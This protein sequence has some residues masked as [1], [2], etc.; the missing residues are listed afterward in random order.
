MHLKQSLFATASAVLLIATNAQAQEA[1][2]ERES[3]IDRVLGTVTVT[4]T[5]K[6]DVEN[7]Q[8]VPVAVTA[9]NSDTLDALNVTT[10][11]SLS[12]SSPNVSLDDVG[13]SRGTANFAIRGLGVNSSIPS[14]DPAV[15]VFIDGVY[16]GVN[17]GVVIDLFDVDS[18]E[19]LRGPQGLLFGRNTTGGAVVVNTGNPSDEFT[20][21]IGAKVDGPVDE[22]RGGN[23]ATVQ[24]YVSGP[25]I[26]GVLNGKIGA[27]YTTDAGYFE[28]QYNG[29]NHGE[30][31]TATY[32]GALEFTP[33]ERLTFLGKV[34]YTDSRGDGPSGSNAG[35]FD[36]DSFDFSI[37][38]P[39]LA[40]SETVF[41]SLRTDYDVDFGNGRITN[42]FGYRDY[43]G[44][45]IGDID[46][47]PITFFHSGAELSQEQFSNE[48]RYAGTFGKADV[49][50]GV[51]YF[52]QEI[53]Y[54]ETR[55][56]RRR[57]YLTLQQHAQANNAGL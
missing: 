44:D 56:S 38:E 23:S 35:Y 32:R 29:D 46:A 53:A 41:G 6:K 15:G 16:L 24:G 36:R 47:S 9:F 20:Y 22:D 40:E 8:D 31:Q 45:S 30:L 34:E 14:I 4:A 5:K 52:E 12:Y 19:I 51:Y 39:G 18:I 7:V 28:N 21:K 42:I 33:T 43:T 3:A 17:S 37:D 26:E 25:L 49:T 54:T 13:T 1:E 2:T 48:L 27:S 55:N 11:E 57:E 10:L 50:T